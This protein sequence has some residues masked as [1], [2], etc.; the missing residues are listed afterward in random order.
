MKGPKH[1]SS[2][3]T[4]VLR[5]REM[6]RKMPKTVSPPETLSP[7]RVMCQAISR[8]AVAILVE[9]PE[10]VAGEAEEA[11]ANEAVAEAGVAKAMEAVAEVEGEALAVRQGGGGGGRSRGSSRG[12]SRGGRGAGS[13]RGSHGN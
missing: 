11:K 2:K 3:R 13:E 12:S 5:A 4:E 9:I 6:G 8:T 10:G 1:P 7:I